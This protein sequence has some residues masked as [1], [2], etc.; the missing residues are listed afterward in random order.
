MD[1]ARRKSISSPMVVSKAMLLLPAR[2]FFARYPVFGRLYRQRAFRLLVV[3]IVI[4]SIGI[5]V[6]QNVLENARY[7]LTAAD[8]ALVGHS[9][10]N[11]DKKLTF[12]AT[13][14]LY[15]F[16]KAGLRQAQQ[17]ANPT[18]PVAKLMSAKVGNPSG[19]NSQQ[20]YSV[21]LPVDL[22]QGITIY[23][24]NT[25]L[26]FK[27]IPN[28]DSAPGK[29]VD[30]HLVYPVADGQ[31]VYT[32]KGNGLKEDMLLNKAPSQGRIDLSYHLQLPSELAAR[33][34]SNG[35]IGIYSADQ[36]LYGNISFGDSTTE[37]KV[38]AA[39]KNGQKTNLIFGLPAPVIKQTSGRS[40]TSPQA[41]FS[42]KGDSLE[43]VAKHLSQASYPLTIDPSVVV[44]STSD[45]MTGNNEDN[46]IDFTT[47]GQ[48][49]RGGLTGGSINS[50]SA[51]WGSTSGITTGTRNFGAV[52]YNGYAYIVGGYTTA[53]TAVVKYAVI[54]SD[55]TLGTWTPTSSLPIAVNYATAV[56][57]NGYIYE[58]GSNNYYALLC[59]GSNS[60][61][62]GC[63]STAGTVG[64]W[65]TTSSLLYPGNE[66]AVVAY[67]GYMYFM[68]GL[69]ASGY[70]EYVVINADGSLGAW[71]LTTSLPGGV[72]TFPAGTAYNG[73]MYILGGYIGGDSS[74]VDYAPINADGTLGTWTATT[75]MLAVNEGLSAVVYGGYI[76][77]IGGSSNSGTSSLMTVS[78][79]PINDNGT[80]GAWTATTSLTT[81]EQNAGT[82][83]YNG[84][85]YEIGGYNGST[86]DSTVEY[87]K[88]D[89]AGTTQAYTSTTAL[90]T[91]T[92]KGKNYTT[93][94]YAQS[95]AYNGYIYEIGGYTN[96]PAV[97]YYTD[98]SYASLS[99]T[100][101]IGAWAS[102]SALSTGIDAFAAY[103]YNGYMYVLGGY[104]GTTTYATVYYSAIS[105][106]G[107]LGAW[108][109]TTSLPAA[110]EFS[111]SVAYGGYLYNIGGMTTNV[112]T[113]AVLTVN[114]ALIC[115][116]SNNGVGGCSTTAGPVGTWA[117]TT[118]LG[119]V[120]YAATSVTYAGYIYQINSS[121]SYYALICTTGNNGVGGCTGTAG[122]VG[123]WNSV[124]NP[125][126]AVNYASSAIYNGYLYVLGGYTGTA[127][128]SVVSSA[129][130]N[131]NGSVGSWTANISLPVAT[132]YASS[133]IYQGYIYEL[134]GYNGS[135][136][137]GTTYYAPINNG[138]S[139][140]V[141][142]WT[143]N[144]NLFTTGRDF[145][146]TVAYNGYLYV[147]GGYS[148]TYRNDVQYAAINTNGSV[149]T[150]APATSFSVPRYGLKAVAYNGYMYVMGGYHGTSDTLCSTVTS[151][152]CSDVQY[153]PISSTGALGASWATSGNFSV[154]RYGFGAVA[155]NGYMYVLGGHTTSTGYVNDVQYA[156]INSSGSVGTWTS[157]SNVFSTGRG[158]H[159]VVAYNGYMYIIGGFNGAY[160][161]DIQYA[162]I[163]SNGTIGSWQLNNQLLVGV[164]SPYV[165]ANN[166]YIY[167]LGG[168]GSAGYLNAVAMAPL[169]SNGTIGP[170]SYTTAF[171]N[172][173]YGLG[174]VVYN[175]YLYVIGGYDGT[176][177]YDDVQYAPLT[178]MA[179]TTRYSK[180]IDLGGLTSLSSI[181]YTGVVPS[182]Y[183]NI[184]YK[185]WAPD[186]LTVLASGLASSVGYTANTSQCGGVITEGVRY[187]QVFVTLD[188]ST[189]GGAVFP[190]ISNANNANIQDLTVNYSVGNSG[191]PAPSQRLHLGKTLQETKTLSALDTCGI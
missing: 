35:G 188:D 18:N 114:Y 68:G 47:A 124:T 57:Y 103:A 129:P 89:P 109:A 27:I 88:I 161:S 94:E 135:A 126:T 80:L 50:T 107:T 83:V 31:L 186:G 167:I 160:L 153:T 149:G 66:A 169:Y 43:L 143:A 90:P 95:I 77:Q 81:A 36:N 120:S 158:F 34:L 33:M 151:F 55:G 71:A 52:N 67:N 76:Y 179:R 12:D 159:G 130:I 30:G 168:K 165:V 58:L 191:H 4:L 74:V 64:T 137:L 5:P 85:I 39:R 100:G 133:A 173:R 152:F 44:T 155:Y 38:M 13:K 178:V 73:Y 132:E 110:S 184:S 87:A 121:A 131:T 113:S 104:D 84:Y 145:H 7:R 42:L 59:T 60:G 49:K 92:S 136:V 29:L 53:A 22:R 46:S 25:G 61:I 56:V 69:V 70:V 98:V 19:K 51:A 177:Y 78:Y 82:F 139:G 123:T 6:L 118:S 162:P 14:Q 127:V 9:N 65:N 8:V 102:T 3:A 99:T 171:T 176:T 170:W 26:N 146:D 28:F 174:S 48:I 37:A 54:N 185:A 134:G 15:Q 156:P 148:G 150:W 125:T 63:T 21:D 108:T 141:G 183:Q 97:L 20:L 1:K 116:G 11:L 172:P 2:R 79:A 157:N 189:Q 187:I 142:S 140:L 128:T 91:Y 138:G 164:Q 40:S 112:T 86:I 62:G 41:S 111:T 17:A 16:N 75:S 175:G 144:T 122:T 117:A 45:F 115:T 32:L 163:N 96:S 147:L 106:T 166:G 10:S 24:N 93:R 23:D 190:D 154:G 180:L 105:S 101:A 182:S 181:T 119:T 72:T